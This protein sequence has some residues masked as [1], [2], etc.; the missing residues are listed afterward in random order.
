MIDFKKYSNPEIV[1]NITDVM[2]APQRAPI[3][4]VKW[5]LVFAVVGVIINILLIS[6]SNQQLYVT[7][8]SS[9]F[10]FFLMAFSGVLLGMY[11][12]SRDLNKSLQTILEYTNTIIHLVINDVCQSFDLVKSAVDGYKINLPSGHE[13]V[14]GVLVDVVNPAATKCF[15]NKIPFVGK[16]AS[17]AY[18]MAIDALLKI[19]SVFFAKVDKE[20]E[21]VVNENLSKVKGV[22]DTPLNFVETTIEKTWM[23][24][25]TDGADKYIGKAKGYVHRT[26]FLTS[27]PIVAFAIAFIVAT[28]SLVYFAL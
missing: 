28:I 1:N 13:I 7:I 4:I 24:K 9:I 3:R 11:S 15:E 14:S 18:S 17:K 5:G 25:I 16:I 21:K 26:Y 19:S 6:F 22:A 8:L 2:S 10:L 20:I 27:V 12:F 23:P